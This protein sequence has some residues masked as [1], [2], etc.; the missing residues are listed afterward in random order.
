MR[1]ALASTLVLALAMAIP[2]STSPVMAKADNMIRIA[3]LAPRDTDLAHNFIKIDR[4]LRE[5]T[6]GTWGI[7]L[8][9]GG[10]AGDEKDVIRKMKV[11]QMD[12][13]LIT[14][15]GLSQIVREVTVLTVPGVID[16]YDRVERVQSAM[17]QEWDQLFDK[18]GFK[19]IAW[20]EVGQVRFFSKTPITKPSDLK[21][22]RPWLWPESYMMKETYKTVGANPVPLSMPEVYGG[23]QT[24]QIDMVWNS[25]IAVVALQWH[26]KLSCVTKQTSGVLLGAMLMTKEKWQS[27]PEDVRKS[28]EEQIKKNIEGDNKET[29]ESDKKALEKLLQRG[30]K[31]TDFS[32]EGKKEY[33]QVTNTVR[34]HLVGRAY[35]KELLERVMK[36]ASGQ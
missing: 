18:G 25:A 12:G 20:G 19:L 9:P 35:P 28:L 21:S 29:R 5:A 11:N 16:T 34:E 2:G 17:K 13:S 7:Q 4:G 33:D 22:M 24:G 15:I 27:I 36:I 6:K 23:L 3:T 10:I 26:T 30:Y 32:P 14:H 31:A 1:K 8:Y